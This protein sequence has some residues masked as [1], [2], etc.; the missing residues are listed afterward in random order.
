MMQ[1]PADVAARLRELR[2]VCGYSVEQLASELSIDPEIYAGYETDGRDIPISVI[3]E[4]ANLFR[5]D[6][7]EILT[8]M[9]GKLDTYHV[10][11]AGEGRPTDRLPGYRFSDLAFRYGHKVMQPLLV[12]LDPSDEMPK[13]VTHKG[14][15]FNF[16]LS[17]AITVVF[18]DREITLHAGDSIYFNPAL[19]HGQ[20][21]ASDVPS[22]FLTVI[23][24]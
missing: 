13:L 7:N 22:S 17:G 1:N 12:T 24:E 20:K 21:C 23:A 6:F 2:E 4:V 10:V 5:V 15:E 18:G 8:G 19:P 16:V 9:G 14:Q 11:R 3:F